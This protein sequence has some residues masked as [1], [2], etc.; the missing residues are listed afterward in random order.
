MFW[1]VDS[2]LMRKLQ[3][4]LSPSPVSYQRRG[5]NVTLKC[6]YQQVLESP[7]DT[8]TIDDELPSR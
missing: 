6:K 5:D 7:S 4:Q 1:I 2:F 8:D 3:K